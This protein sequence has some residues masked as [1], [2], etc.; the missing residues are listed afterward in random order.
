M[1]HK[2]ILLKIENWLFYLLNGLIYEKVLALN[3]HHTS[4]TISYMQ[5]DDQVLLVK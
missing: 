2:V 5:A 4:F 3:V 1:N